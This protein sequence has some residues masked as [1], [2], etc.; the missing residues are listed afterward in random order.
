MLGSSFGGWEIQVSAY[1][2]VSFP[3]LC[4]MVPSCLSFLAPLFH[5]TLHLAHLWFACHILSF[6]AVSLPLFWLLSWLPRV[7]TPR[8]SPSSLEDPTSPHC[9]S[10]N[11]LSVMMSGVGLLHA[12]HDQCD[13]AT[14]RSFPYTHNLF[15]RSTGH[16]RTRAV[17][18][19]SRTLGCAS[20]SSSCSL[21]R[22]A[23]L[24]AVS[25][26][27]SA[28]CGLQR[29]SLS[30]IPFLWAFL[31]SLLPSIAGRRVRACAFPC[32]HSFVSQPAIRPA[33]A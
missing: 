18:T 27:Q 16:K 33:K 12:R 5:C 32:A 22:N 30:T 4:S 9:V 13:P 10:H 24:C 19:C 31:F 15:S 7:N 11:K 1:T 3:W 2:C 26:T 25:C 6:H 8:R 21:Y 23:Y 29:S 20:A 28:L 17:S 14:R